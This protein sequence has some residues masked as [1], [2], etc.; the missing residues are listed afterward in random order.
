MKT[1]LVV[2]FS[3]MFLAPNFVFGLTP[4][5]TKG[6]ES[7]A[8]CYACH[9][10]ELDPPL[11]PPM[12]QVQWRYKRDYSTKNIFVSKIVSFVKEPKEEN[13]LMRN[14]VNELNLMPPMPLPDTTLINIAHYIFEHTFPPP[15]KHWKSAMKRFKQKGDLSHYNRANQ[16]YNSLCVKIDK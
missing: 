3:L 11:G 5:A 15:C 7:F 1:L 4:E 6:A 14:A 16:R 10:P 8:F 12:Y 9:N 13:A 2:I